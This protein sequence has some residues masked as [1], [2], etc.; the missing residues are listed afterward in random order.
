MAKVPMVITAALTVAAGIAAAYVLRVSGLSNSEVIQA[1]IGIFATYGALVSAA[2]VVYS[3]LQTNSAFIESQRPQLYIRVES[4]R[5]RE[6]ATATETEPGT[7]IHYKNTTANQFSDLTIG[8]KVEAA[9]KVCDLG[10]QFQPCMVMI[11]HD[12]R[13][14]WFKTLQALK[15]KGCDLPA[16]AASAPDVY[17][18][19]CYSFTHARER[20]VVP[21]QDYKWDWKL[22]QWVLP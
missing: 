6:N 21:C 18:K 5:V 8:I 19:L 13:Q 20:K 15:E 12:Q 10:D 14:K 4:I 11:G 16:L 9:G 7:R 2:F 1:Q 22:E 17:L 3:Y